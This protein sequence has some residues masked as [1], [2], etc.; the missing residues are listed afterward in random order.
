MA[1]LLSCKDGEFFINHANIYL[2]KINKK[3]TE[4]ADHV[5]SPVCA[6]PLIKFYL[7]HLFL[8]TCGE[9]QFD[10]VCCCEEVR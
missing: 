4:K 2:T 1:I 5:V 6:I 10:Y 3:L 8:V 9:F 7:S